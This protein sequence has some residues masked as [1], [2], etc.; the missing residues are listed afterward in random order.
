MSIWK[1]HQ[2][3]ELE[4]GWTPPLAHTPAAAHS[5]MTSN[6]NIVKIHFAEEHGSANHSRIFHNIWSV[7]I[8]TGSDVC[9]C[10][11][12]SCV[13]RHDGY[14]VRICRSP[15]WHYHFLLSESHTVQ[16]FAICWWT[17]WIRSKYSRGCLFKEWRNSI[18]IQ[19]S[20]NCP[21]F[22]HSISMARLSS[23]NVLQVSGNMA[24]KRDIRHSRRQAQSTCTNVMKAS[25]RCAAMG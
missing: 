23:F 2:I 13:I 16:S 8:W 9:P 25:N 18:L 14:T 12:M 17:Q 21:H 10:L 5:Q 20:W 15:K 19:P 3:S 7:H 4:A 11:F 1:R 22:C 24:R 6:G